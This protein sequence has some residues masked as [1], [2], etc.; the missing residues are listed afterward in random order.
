MLRLRKILLYDN[1]YYLIFFIIL[2]LVLIRININNNLVIKKDYIDGTIIDYYY[3]N[4]KMDFI[5]KNNK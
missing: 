2:A 5:I 4:L 1:I 3:D